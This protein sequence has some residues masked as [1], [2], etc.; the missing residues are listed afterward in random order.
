MAQT[1]RDNLKRAFSLPTNSNQL[2][3][4]N[5]TINNVNLYKGS[6]CTQTIFKNKSSKKDT[7]DIN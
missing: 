1:T 4:K 6:D 2:A 5:K 3:R 7:L